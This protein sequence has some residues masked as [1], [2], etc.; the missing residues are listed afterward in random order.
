MKRVNFIRTIGLAG[1]GLSVPGLASGMSLNNSEDLPPLL[2]DPEG[3]PIVSVQGWEKQ[4]ELFKND[5]LITWAPWIQTQK[6]RF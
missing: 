2:F 1:I 3:K 5:G 6:P 4:R